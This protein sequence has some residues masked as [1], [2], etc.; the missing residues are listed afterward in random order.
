MKIVTNHQPRLLLD[1]NQLTPKEQAEFDN[2]EDREEMSYIRY[3]G[4]VYCTNEFM[5]LLGHAPWE[6]SH[7][8]SFFSAVLIRFMPEDPDSVIMGLMLS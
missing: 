2:D 8:D 3:R 4:R 5:Y 1:W 6:G 7:S